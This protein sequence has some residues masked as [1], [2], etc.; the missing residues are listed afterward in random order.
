MCQSRHWFIGFTVMSTPWRV[1]MAIL[2]TT[3]NFNFIASSWADVNVVQWHV[4]PISQDVR[5]PSCRRQLTLALTLCQCSHYLCWFTLTASSYVSTEATAIQDDLCKRMCWAES[6]LNQWRGSVAVSSERCN[7]T[8]PLSSAVK[9]CDVLITGLRE[10]ALVSTASVLLITSASCKFHPSSLQ[11][12][13]ISTQVEVTCLLPQLHL[14]DTIV[15]VKVDASIKTS[16][17]TKPDF[18]YDV[19]SEADDFHFPPSPISF[20][21]FF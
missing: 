21:W 14:N 20:P 7:G 4:Q 12:T 16:D 9:A 3:I 18:Y 6:N 10:E 8:V 13:A 2:L 17:I 11:C 5:E 15:E 19:M 1:E